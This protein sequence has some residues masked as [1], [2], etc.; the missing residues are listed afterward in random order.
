M[1]RKSLCFVGPQQVEIRAEEL[2]DPGSGEARLISVCSAISTGT[3]LL[4]YKGEAPADL[5]ADGMLPSLGSSLAYPLKYGYS[6]VGK[7]EAIGAGVD[8]NWLGKQVFAFNPHETAF[9]ARVKDLQPL[10]GGC[11]PQDAAW[12][13]AVETAVNLILDGDP[14]L[15]E[16][17]VVLGQGL[18]GLLTTDLLARHPLQTLLTFDAYPAR[19]MLSK[20]FGAQATFDPLSNIN[21]AQALLGVQRADLVYELTGNPAA[22][23]LALELVGD[24]GRVV[25]G[26]WYGERRAALNLGGHFHRGRIKLISSQV[27]QIEPALRGRWDQARRFAVAWQALAEIQPSRLVNRVLPLEQAGEAYNLLAREP[28]KCLAILFT[29]N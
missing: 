21:E 28:E 4:L 14:R 18:I 24:H 8:Q 12:L 29:Y 22:L 20:Q 7:V 1:K 5:A 17:V 9:N 11:S 25:V 16:Q 10:P 27:S 3:E 23:D 26:S 19:R 6:M 15:G 2:A 13:P